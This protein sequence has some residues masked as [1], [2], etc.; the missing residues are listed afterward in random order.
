MRRSITILFIVSLI[1][2][3][4]LSCGMQ[5]YESSMVSPEPKTGKVTES[6][7][8]PEEPPKPEP[9]TG[10]IS[11]SGPEPEEASKPE[12][13]P[14]EEKESEEKY[15]VEIVNFRFSPATLKIQA[16]TK[17]TWINK[18]RTFHSV[19]SDDELFSSGNLAKGWTFSYI[20]E[21]EGTYEYHCEPH[22]YMK[23]KVIV[24]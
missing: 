16:G 5:G 17:V 15:M 8:T 1:S 7:K 11:K 2:F 19:T 10:E 3:T 21:T 22:S 20:F 12:E 13:K 23:G 9:K 4:V 24:E 18:D 14:V 6:V